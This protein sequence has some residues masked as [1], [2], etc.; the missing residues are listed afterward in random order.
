[1]VLFLKLLCAHILGDFIFQPHKW[2]LCKEEKKQKSPYLYWH[3]AVHAVATLIVLEFN[4]KYW[5]GFVLITSSH[6]L[7]DIWKLQLKSNAKSFLPFVIDQLAHISVILTTVYYYTPFKINLASLLTPQLLLLILCILFI[8]NV[9]AIV[10][11][12]FITKLNIPQIKDVET[13]DKAGT[14]VG[15]IER[16]FVFSFIIINFWI[17]IGFLIIAKALFNVSSM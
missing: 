5:F 7:I 11:K 2:V 14:L 6:L 4:P 1:M 13:K 9:S 16:L 3:I 15:I 17:G 8:T 10:M 12:V